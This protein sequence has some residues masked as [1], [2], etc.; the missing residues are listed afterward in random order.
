MRLYRHQ[1][2]AD[3]IQREVSQIIREELSDPELQGMITISF[4]EVSSDLRKARIFYQVHGGKEAEEA[5]ARGFGRA[6]SYIRHLLAERLYIK[7][8]PEI[9]FELDRRQDVQDQ[10]EALFEKLRK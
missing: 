7:F 6:G 3:F 9:I 10:L 2:L 5:A 1:R 8:V 4:V